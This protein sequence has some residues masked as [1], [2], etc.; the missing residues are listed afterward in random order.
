MLGRK[1]SM[2]S[3]LLALAGMS[4]FHVPRSAPAPRA[5]LN[6]RTARRGRMKNYK[7]E[8]KGNKLA[9]AAANGRVGL[10]NGMTFQQRYHADRLNLV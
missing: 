10:R 6:N 5:R 8:V 9:K 2:I 7:V 1:F 3:T 4:S